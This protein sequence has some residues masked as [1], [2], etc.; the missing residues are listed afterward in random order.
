MRTRK[1][2]LAGICA[3]AMLLGMAALSEGTDLPGRPMQAEA[4]SVSSGKMQQIQASA[5]PYDEYERAIWYGFLTEE[6]AEEDPDTTYLTQR[7]YLDMMDRMIA[8]LKPERLERWKNLTKDMSDRQLH[9]DD[10]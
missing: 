7:V 1:R 6:Y 9:R 2:L 4:V 10:A 3:S 5:M 8:K